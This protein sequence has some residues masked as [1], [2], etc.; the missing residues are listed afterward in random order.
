MQNTDGFHSV[1]SSQDG[2]LS[3]ISCWNGFTN[4]K[5]YSSS[6][7]TLTTKETCCQLTTMKTC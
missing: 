7:L 5:I 1:G 3:S 4:S 6:L 2:L